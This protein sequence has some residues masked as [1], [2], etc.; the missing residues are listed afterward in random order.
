MTCSVLLCMLV[1]WTR[2]IM[3]RIVVSGIRYAAF[4]HPCSP[5][6]VIFFYYSLP[7]LCLDC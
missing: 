1:S 2:G 6:L 4:H 5:S 7:F 3:C